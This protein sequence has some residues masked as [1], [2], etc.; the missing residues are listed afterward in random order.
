MKLRAVDGRAA[1]GRFI[2]SIGPVDGTI[3]LRTAPAR[4]AARGRRTDD[5]HHGAMQFGSNREGS[6]GRV[7]PASIRLMLRKLCN[8]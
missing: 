1:L 4:L 5:H 6:R 7:G 2:S 3:S 8:P